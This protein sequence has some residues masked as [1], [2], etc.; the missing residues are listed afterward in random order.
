MGAINYNFCGQ[1]CWV[2]SKPI[3]GCGI[4]GSLP[5]GG[6][7]CFHP[8]CYKN[9]HKASQELLQKLEEEGKLFERMLADM[10]HKG[11]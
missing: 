10:A 2:C 6:C 3:M 5:E 4:I 7:T 11:D 8:E 9:W 1:L